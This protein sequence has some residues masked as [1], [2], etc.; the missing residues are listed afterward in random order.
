M[1]KIFGLVIIA[2]FVLASVGA[3]AAVTSTKHNFVTGGPGTIVGGITVCQLC[4][5]PH[6]GST[7][8]T[9]L[10]IWSRTNPVNTTFTVYNGVGAGNNGVTL[11]GTTVSMPGTFS[12]T[13]L[14]CH[15]GSLGIN[16]IT[17]N[18]VSNT[19]AITSNNVYVDDTTGLLTTATNATTGYKP[20]LLQD[21]RNDH[22]I[23]LEYRGVA[24]TLAGL[25]AA[26]ATNVVNGAYSYPLFGAATNIMECATC[27]DPHDS[28]AGRQPMLRGLTLQLCQDC[29]STK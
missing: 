1:K 3:Y 15:D 5:I 13:C 22:P 6:G 18:A 17:K 9:G 12:L 26:G 8:T 29:H 11:S 24:A 10:P 28:P 16:T 4:H 21:L 20:N 27:H 23:G 25:R 2:A 19:Y 14:G 7:A